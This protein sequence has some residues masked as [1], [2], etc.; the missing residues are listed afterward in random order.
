MWSLKE[1]LSYIRGKH[2]LKFGYSFES[3][4]ANGF[5]QQNIAG[6]ATFSFAETAVP[7]ATSNSSGSSFASFLL[8][9][10]DSGAT[11]TVRYLPQTYDYHGFYAQDDWRI[12]KRLIL[13]LGL[14]YEFT[15]PPVSGGDQYSDFTPNR[16]NPAVDN[17]PGALRFA[18]DGAG[19]SG[20]RSLVPGWYGGIGPR[21]GLAYTLNDKTTIRSGYARTF[22]RVTV[23][24]SSNHYSGFIGQ[25]NFASPDQGI[26]PAFNWD[27]GLPSYPLPP[28][29]NPSF[30]NNQNVDWWTAR[31]PPARR[32]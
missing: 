18:G 28:Q 11:E 20:T 17:N 13:N 4:R 7:G 29:I 14:R 27:A 25:Y 23:V 10:A 19:R 32:N 2:T 1:D 8:G 16:A 6:Q 3:Q 24:A 15:K 22:S 12:T 26:T 30:Q 9:N 31:M 21:L 5:G